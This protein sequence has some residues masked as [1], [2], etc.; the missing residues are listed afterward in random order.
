MNVH[1][2]DR[3]TLDRRC[4]QNGQSARVCVFLSLSPLSPSSHVG[5]LRIGEQA[6]QPVRPEYS[7]GLTTWFPINTGIAGIRGGSITFSRL[8]SM[9]TVSIS[10]V[11]A[12]TGAEPSENGSPPGRANSAAPGETSLQQDTGTR[13]GCDSAQSRAECS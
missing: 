6:A 1:P 10:P 12:R 7:A 3:K 5:S 11:W 13:S 2:E 9:K 8:V 4:Y